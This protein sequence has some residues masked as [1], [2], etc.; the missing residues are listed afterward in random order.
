MGNDLIDA[1][2][3]DD[4]VTLLFW[5]PL[6]P[7]NKNLIVGMAKDSITDCKV[8]TSLRQGRV[9]ILK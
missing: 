5:P 7:S 3:H 4:G 8:K 6:S 1:I 9:E 2:I